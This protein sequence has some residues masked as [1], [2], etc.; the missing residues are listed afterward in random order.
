MSTM[1]AFDDAVRADQ[2]P[3]LIIDLT[4]VAYVDS[5]GIVLVGA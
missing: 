2:T 5:A 4:N 3:S 1:E